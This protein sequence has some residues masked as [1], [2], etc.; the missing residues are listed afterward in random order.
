[1]QVWSMIMVLVLIGWLLL[2]TRS[3]IS[4]SL[5]RALTGRARS[6]WLLTGEASRRGVPQTFSSI[7]EN[8]SEQSGC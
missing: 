7:E 1:M 2:R 6:V 3:V 5:R 8:L 4:C